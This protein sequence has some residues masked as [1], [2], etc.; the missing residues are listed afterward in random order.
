MVIERF[1]FPECVVLGLFLGN[2]DFLSLVNTWD[3]YS[4]MAAPGQRFRSTRKKEVG[5]GLSKRNVF[6]STGGFLWPHCQFSSCSPR[7]LVLCAHG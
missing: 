4:N 6:I 2:I 3:A 7:V 5:G 1:P